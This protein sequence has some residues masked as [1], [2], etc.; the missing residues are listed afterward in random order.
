MKVNSN[1]LQAA[2]VIMT[3]VAIPLFFLS[4]CGAPLNVK[5]LAT[6]EIPLLQ[7]PVNYAD[8]KYI[9]VP[10]DTLQI[11][12]VFH[13]D[14]N[15][16]A[17]VQPDGKITA[18]LAG[19][20]TVAGMTTAKLEELLKQRTSDQLR[21]PEVVVNISKFAERNVYIGGEVAKP[22]L[23]RYRK[24][25]TPLQAVI[26]SGGFLESARA[27]SVVLIRGADSPND[28]VS[29]KLNLTESVAES[30]KEPLFLAPHDVVY[31]PKTSISEANLWVRQH[32]TDLFPFLFPGMS[33]ATGVLRSMK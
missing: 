31:V 4:A 6:E 17:V 20:V 2:K 3:V 29:R 28:F 5:P 33:S 26:A 9:I 14:M 10:D 1:A 16:E 12:Y 21:D 22:G 15:Q 25:L 7:P 32:I 24:G 30:I 11:R 8:E 27:D 23:V 18:A 13:P 19:Q